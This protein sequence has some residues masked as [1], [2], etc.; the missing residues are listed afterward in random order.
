MRA[1]A[2][3]RREEVDTAKLEGLFNALKQG[4]LLYDGVSE[5]LVLKTTFEKSQ[6]LVWLS[7]ENTYIPNC[8]NPYHWDSKTGKV[9]SAKDEVFEF[10]DMQIEPEGAPARMRKY[11][12]LPRSADLPGT[13]RYTD[14]TMSEYIESPSGRALFE[15]VRDAI[16]NPEAQTTQDKV[17]LVLKHVG[18]SATPKAI[19]AVLAMLHH[20][21][22]K[23][24]S[25]ISVGDLDE[26]HEKLAE[27][28]G[29]D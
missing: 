27:A 28:L 6:K 22:A 11:Q 10:E 12:G 13:E 17:A 29:R 25:I 8:E 7:N 5:V 18:L 19:C 4:D 21:P 2:H 20:A 1:V 26:I 15:Y 16:R 23:K 24:I 3:Q 14:D 9:V